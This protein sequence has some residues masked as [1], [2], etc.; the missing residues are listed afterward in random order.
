MAKIEIDDQELKK[1]ICDVFS[2]MMI[3]KPLEVIWEEGDPNEDSKDIEISNLRNQ[4]AICKSMM[5]AYKE[6]LEAKDRAIRGYLRTKDEF[7]V[8][9]RTCEEENKKLAMEVDRLNNDVKTYK[10]IVCDLTK[11]CDKVKDDIDQEFE[12]TI[13]GNLMNLKVVKK[14]LDKV[15]PFA[16]TKD[17]YLK[18]MDIINKDI[19]NL[20]KF[21]EERWGYGKEE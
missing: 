1:V 6:R 14:Y 2:E 13:H 12:E 3:N 20:D 10:E 15:L 8:R 17:D 18:A 5:A 9:S 21:I 16:K 7:R 19:S 4:I 11:A